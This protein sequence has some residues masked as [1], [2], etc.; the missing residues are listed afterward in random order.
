[1]SIDQECLGRFFDTEEETGEAHPKRKMAVR[2]QKQ[3]FDIVPFINEIGNRVNSKS[4]SL[5]DL[6]EERLSRSYPN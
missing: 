4:T 3:V 6:L 5:F 2:T 1:M